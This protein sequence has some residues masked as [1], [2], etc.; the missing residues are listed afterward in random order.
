MDDLQTKPKGTIAILVVFAFLI[1][2]LWGSVYL[3]MLLR[4]ATQ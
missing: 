2:I 3:A 1:V 4:G